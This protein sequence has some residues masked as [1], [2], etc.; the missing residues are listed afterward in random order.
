MGLLTHYPTR[1]LGVF[2]VAFVLAFAQ[3][4]S[5]FFEPKYLQDAHGWE[6][7]H[8]SVLGFCGGFIALFGSSWAGRF[9]DRHGRRRTLMG[10]MTLEAL[11][12]IAF[13]QA[14]G[15]L[16]PPIWVTMGS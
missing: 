1:F 2:G 7:W 3:Y 4:A 16:L 10:F 5:S 14:S 15:I 9:S 13:Y 8:Y 11:L 6:P 12:T